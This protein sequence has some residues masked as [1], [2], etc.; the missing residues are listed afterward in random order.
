MSVFL[1]I[2]ID[3]ISNSWSSEEMCFLIE[4]TNYRLEIHFEFYISLRGIVMS[5]K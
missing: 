3:I 1:N 5:I 4:N 2:G